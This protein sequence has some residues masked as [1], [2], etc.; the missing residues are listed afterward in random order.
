MKR[1]Q[2]III[3][4]RKSRLNIHFHSSTFHV[5]KWHL[6]EE[7]ITTQKGV[8]LDVESAGLE[9]KYEAADKLKKFGFGGWKGPEPHGGL[10]R[11]S[12]FKRDPLYTKQAVDILKNFNKTTTPDSKPF[13]FAVNLVKRR[14][15]LRSDR[16]LTAV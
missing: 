15:D 7:D 11:D 13:F 9:Q 12:G 3:F 10:Y 5:G 1:I 8:R 2:K 16:M 6:S 14:V 4:T